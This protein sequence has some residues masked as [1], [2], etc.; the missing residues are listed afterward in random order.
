MYQIKVYNKTDNVWIEIIT[1]PFIP[2]DGAFYPFTC[3][4]CRDSRLLIIRKDDIGKRMPF[5]CK[6]G[7][8]YV[9]IVKGEED[10]NG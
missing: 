1:V 4:Y 9:L 3:P 2:E 7:K 10:G 6:C 5:K 8:D